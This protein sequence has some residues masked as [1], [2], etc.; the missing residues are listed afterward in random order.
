MRDTPFNYPDK[1][2]AET[3]IREQMRREIASDMGKE[4]AD[5][6]D[7]ASIESL[8]GDSLDLLEVVMRLER[9]FDIDIPDSDLGTDRIGALLDVAE[10][11]YN[12]RA[13]PNTSVD[14]D[15]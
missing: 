2:M 7:S 12:R 8:G 13:Q 14:A 1:I 10:K 3:P 5:C 11:R 15:A 9:A 6:T 4:I